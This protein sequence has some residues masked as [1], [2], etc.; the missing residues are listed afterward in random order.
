MGNIPTIPAIKFVVTKPNPDDYL[1]HREEF[2]SYSD[3]ES[4]A[5][6]YFYKQFKEWHYFAIKDGYCKNM[7][8]E[9]YVKEV[10][11]PEDI[12]EVIIDNGW[13]IIRVP[14][15]DSSQETVKGI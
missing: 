9:E 4:W 14:S 10:L 2:E 11:S 8:V 7:E 15:D 3:L 6:E 13:K 1:P 12:E 5:I